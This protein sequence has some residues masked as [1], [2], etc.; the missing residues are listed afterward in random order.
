MDWS[1][2]RGIIK[3]KIGSKE[4]AS[5]PEIADIKAEQSLRNLEI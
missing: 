3:K 4:L 2:F 5:D 1:I